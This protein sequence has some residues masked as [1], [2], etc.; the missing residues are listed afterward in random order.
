[1][2]LWFCA[3]A[4]GAQPVRILVV[5][6]GHPCQTSFY[7]LFEGHDGIVATVDIHPFPDR[8][9]DLRK[10]YDVLVLYDP[11]QEITERDQ[12]VLRNFLESGKGLVVLHHA[13]GLLQLEMVVRG[14]C[15]PPHDLVG[16]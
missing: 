10:K 15:P 16:Q 12:E 3:I 7:A 8:R 2:G 13:G 5:T 4:T 6:G 1:V 11:M 9:G 14:G